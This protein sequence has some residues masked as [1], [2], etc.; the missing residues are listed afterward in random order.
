M[1]QIELDKLIT[2]LFKSKIIA[3]KSIK[4]TRKMYEDYLYLDKD[5][6]NSENNMYKFTFVGVIQSL[7]NNV[8]IVYPKYI[9]LK[10]IDYDYN[11]NQKKFFQIMQVITKYKKRMSQNLIDPTESEEIIN[12]NLGTMIQIIKTYY[13]Y[14]LF[15]SERNSYNNNGNGQVL[16]NKTVNMNTPYIVN[17]IPIYLDLQA[18][19]KNIDSLNIVRTIQT[20]ILNFISKKISPV[21]KILNIPPVFIDEIESYDKSKIDYYVN[22]LQYALKNE[23]ITKKQELIIELLIFL[24]NESKNLPN[25]IEVFGTINFELVWEDVCSY[26]YSNHLNKSLKELKLYTKKNIDTTVKLKEYIE[27]PKW[28]VK[29]GNEVCQKSTL[30]LDILNIEKPNFTIYDA[31]YYNLEVSDKQ[32]KNNPGIADVTKQYLYQLAFSELIETNQLKP[33]NYFIMPKDELSQ[34]NT[35]ITTVYLDMF[36][37]LNL[38]PIKVIG[39]DCEKIFK[40]YLKY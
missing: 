11:N 23:F 34:D 25:D 12:N 37:S 27:K 5:L 3:S 1:T 6:N 19:E 33:N 29:N 30:K 13:S 2:R 16:W 17:N 22:I 26:T 36:D 7:K 39:R 15:N 40:E 35:L 38:E 9:S 24:K 18:I 20:C 31:K 4:S 10:N 21:L 32:V 14:G 8:I 28:L